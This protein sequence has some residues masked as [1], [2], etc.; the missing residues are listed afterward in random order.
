MSR[1]EEDI[2]S[3]VD[4]P[5]MRN[6]TLSTYPASYS[7][8]CDTF[9]PRLGSAR[10]TDPGRE[11]FIHFLVPSPVRSRFVAE[12]ASEGGPACIENGLR[13]AGLSESGGVHI[14][15]R[16]VVEL[17]HDAHRELVVKVTARMADTG[18]KVRRLT[19]FAGALCDSQFVGQPPQIPR[20]LDL[21]PRGEGRE[22]FKSQ[23]DADAAV[24]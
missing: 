8:L 19:F 16:D 13:Q 3:R 1:T 15:D 18:A 14:A 24:H 6:T 20:V 9:R 17:S 4:V 2:L 7:E 22:V 10:R 23:I 12:H 11:R 21:L 5:I